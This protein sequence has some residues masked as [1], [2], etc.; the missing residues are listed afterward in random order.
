MSLLA[1]L[2]LVL[3]GAAAAQARIQGRRLAAFIAGWVALAAALVSPLHELAGEHLS[4]HMLQH[5]VLMLLA[6][7]LLALARIGTTMLSLLAGKRRRF[8]ARLIGQARLS[9]FSAW[10]LHAATLWIWH[11][12]AL[13][14]ASVTQPLMHAAQHLSSRAFI[15]RS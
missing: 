3:L 13:Y 10:A 4:A 1:A 8:A 7:P 9:M 14:D 2:F 11:V 15:A 12:P 6:A 5:E